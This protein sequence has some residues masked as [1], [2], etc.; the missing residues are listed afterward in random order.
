MVKL[1]YLP[2]CRISRVL[3]LELV[4]KKIKFGVAKPSFPNVVNNICYSAPKIT[5]SSVLILKA[6]NFLL[7]VLGVSLSVHE[8]RTVGRG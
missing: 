8:T 3:Y 4:S 1:V 7:L 5:V 2:I 6:V